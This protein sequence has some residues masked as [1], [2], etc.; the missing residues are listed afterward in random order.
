VPEKDEYVPLSKLFDL[1]GKGAVVTGAAFGVGLGIARRLAEAGA[2]V[3]IADVNAEAAKQAVERLASQGFK[4]AWVRCDVAKSSEVKAAMQTAVSTLGNLSILVN[5]AGIYPFKPIFDMTEADWDEVID[6]NLKGA[7]L[8]AQEA[9]RHMVRQGRGG[10]IINIGST[11]SVQPSFFPGLV[12]Y[13]AAKG[14]LLLLTKSL[15][16]ELAPYGIRVN[17]IA[18]GGIDPRLTEQSRTGLSIGEGPVKAGKEF[19]QRV[20]LGRMGRPDDIGTVAL[21]LASEAS[22]YMTGSLIVVDGGYLVS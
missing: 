5:N 22:S 1:S 20:L 13:A 4:A 16:K 6:I 19:L 18:A 9:S 12:H 14:G 11:S 8:C 3:L 10:C 15:A 2:G 17:I 7:Y 21:F